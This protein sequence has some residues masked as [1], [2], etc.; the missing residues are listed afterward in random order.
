MVLKRG[1]AILSSEITS[2]QTYLRRREFLRSATL[3][4]AA[5]LAGG[6]DLTAPASASAA[7]LDIRKRTATTTDAPTS[8]DAITTFNNFYEFG[9]DKADPAKNSKNFKPRPWSVAV[10]GECA[11]P[12]V[13]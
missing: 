3:G 12:G 6:F 8:F 13:Y 2:H 9:S 11:K 7:T 10:D 4:A 1:P 5:A